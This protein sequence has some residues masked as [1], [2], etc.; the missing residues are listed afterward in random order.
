MR[1]RSPA[2]GATRKQLRESFPGAAE[3]AAPR[4]C[5]SIRE[6]RFKCLDKREAGTPAIDEMRDRLA[7]QLRAEKTKANS[8][9][10]VTR[11]LEAN[12]TAAAA[13]RSP[14]PAAAAKSSS[15]NNASP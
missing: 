8:E 7:A 4:S 15:P 2:G 10:H 14:E 11:L 12:R 1:S 9:A 5:Q 3:T 13:V 6:C